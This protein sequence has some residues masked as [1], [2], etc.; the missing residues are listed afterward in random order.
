MRTLKTIHLTR[1][2]GETLRYDLVQ[3]GQQFSIKEEPRFLLDG[4]FRDEPET[5]EYGTDCD[6]AWADLD[7]FVQIAINDLDWTL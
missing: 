1:E 2:P 7:K 5:V 3:R 4:T 6:K